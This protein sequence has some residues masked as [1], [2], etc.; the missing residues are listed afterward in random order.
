[1]SKKY[2][3][4]T[5]WKPNGPRFIY[6][7][8][9]DLFSEL[10]ESLE[11]P[12][13]KETKSDEEVQKIL[14]NPEGI[15]IKE[16]QII[17]VWKIDKELRKEVRDELDL[18]YRHLGA[19]IASLIATRNDMGGYK[20]QD[21]SK[22]IDN[23]SEVLKNIIVN[24]YK[25]TEQLIQGCE[26]KV[27]LSEKERKLLVYTRKVYLKAL[28]ETIE[29]LFLTAANNTRR[30]EIFPRD[31]QKEVLNKISEL[32]KK[33]Q[34]L[35]RK[36]KQKQKDQQ[37]KNHEGLEE[38][39]TS[40]NVL[41]NALNSSFPNLIDG[42][43]KLNEAVQK[44]ITEDLVKLKEVQQQM[45]KESEIRGGTVKKLNDLV[46][47]IEEKTSQALDWVQIRSYIK[48]VKVS[49]KKI[50]AELVKN[51]ESGRIK[52]T[53]PTESE[54]TG[55]KVSEEDKKLMQ[56][57]ANEFSHRLKEEST[58]SEAKEVEQIQAQVLQS[59]KTK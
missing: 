2:R 50:T 52:K 34:S 21:K 17:D 51:E 12:I 53:I 47:E 46:K 36:S 7:V 24:Q 5:S 31:E 16:L 33:I 35:T 32:K 29:K 18:A 11:T 56:D 3:I 26:Q 13:M 6:D 20:D 39:L 55:D 14:D 4:N 40:L 22:N 8:I 42:E 57:I 15:K 10:N 28:S 45:G 25:A 19:E 30:V 27:E 59:T 54:E 23:K 58:D 49:L 48:D 43:N 41:K 1:M 38:K 37:K 9:M 44:S